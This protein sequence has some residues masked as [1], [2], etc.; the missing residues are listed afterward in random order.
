MRVI[1]YI[2]PSVGRRVGIIDDD[3]VYDLTS[4][5]PE[6]DSVYEI[7]QLSQKWDRDFDTTIDSLVN[8]KSNKQAILLDYNQLLESKI[9][10]LKPYLISPFDHP[11][12]HKLLISGTGLTHTGSMQSRD[13]MHTNN[14]ESDSAKMFNMGLKGGKPE[15]GKRGVSPEWFYKGNGNIL[16]S[17]GDELVIPRFALDG[18]EE[19]EVAA[20]YFI[21]R[22]GNPKRVGF[23]LGNE[24]SDHETEKINYLYLAPSK[25]RS[26]SIGP[27]LVT[28]LNFDAIKIRC[29]VER[30]QKVIYDSGEIFSGEDYMSHSLSNCEDHHFKYPLHRVPNDAHIHFFGT[31]KLSFSTRDWK[32]K[33]GDIIKV[34]SEQFNKPLINLV[35]YGFEN[36]SNV[37]YV[38][39]A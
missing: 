6:I 20:C 22:N 12:K 4:I 5:Y 15:Q 21:D 14:N 28:D 34:F 17:H 19:P 13:Q 37:F 30:S 32:Y 23:S 18:G 29:T 11:E 27:E 8:N 36:E 39:K 3:K 25:L 7:F 31:S 2:M 10:G 35:G 16:K 24:W 26:C 9:G 33:K 1:Q 38:D